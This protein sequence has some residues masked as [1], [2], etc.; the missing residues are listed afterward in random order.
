MA[1][2]ANSFVVAA[3]VVAVDVVVGAGAESGEPR[4]TEA[5]PR[6]TAAC[7]GSKRH[8]HTH[9]HTD[10]VKNTHVVQ[11]AMSG[12]VDSIHSG[13]LLTCAHRT[14]PSRKNGTKSALFAT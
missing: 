10:Q 9:T 11:I 14:Y 1:A 6:T 12:S 7:L 13:P 3:V 2:G 8:T 4:G 5:A